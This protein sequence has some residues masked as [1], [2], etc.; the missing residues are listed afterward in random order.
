MYKYKVLML[1][2]MSC[3]KTLNKYARDGWRVI[4]MLS[5]PE[6]RLKVIVTFERELEETEYEDD[7]D[8][9]D[10][11]MRTEPEVSVIRLR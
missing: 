5:A 11:P 3:E 10:L 7:E 4:S 1:K 8:Y 9:A 2:A 6:D